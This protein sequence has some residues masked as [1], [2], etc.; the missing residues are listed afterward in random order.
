MR[1]RT[2]QRYPIMHCAAINK[3]YRNGTTRAPAACNMLMYD[4]NTYCP[5]AILESLPVTSWFY[6]SVFRSLLH[7]L[8]IF[9]NKTGMASVSV[10]ASHRE[11]H[12]NRRNSQRSNKNFSSIVL[13]HH[14]REELRTILKTEICAKD[15]KA[16]LQGPKGSRGRRGRRGLPGPRGRMGPRGAIGK[17]GPRGLQG[18]RGPK[19]I[20]GENGP[21]GP[22]GPPGPRGQKGPK[23]DTADPI[24]APAIFVPPKDLVVN[25]SDTVRLKCVASGNPL[26]K[27]TWSR[28]SPL[29]AGR[30]VIDSNG[31][32][33]IKQ[34]TSSDAGRYTCRAISVLGMANASSNLIVQGQ[35]A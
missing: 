27:V 24:E 28:N 18:D 31:F 20:K 8:D 35:C 16:C 5:R 7:V 10:T 2:L 13:R 33:S 19:G 17:H 34:V 32:L 30:H 9:L 11:G 6:V 3:G 14:I 22:T 12:R 25:E 26:P 29:P 4:D 23:G 21:S 1:S 15:Y